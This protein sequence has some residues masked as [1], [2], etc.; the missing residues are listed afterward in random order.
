MLRAGALP[1]TTV[2]WFMDK[3]TATS[4]YALYDPSTVGPRYD[5][6]MDKSLCLNIG[7]GAANFAIKEMIAWKG[8]GKK[9]AQ[10]V[11][12]NIG[13]AGTI[14]DINKGSILLAVYTDVGAN[15]PAYVFDFAVKFKDA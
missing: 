3:N 10:K 7:G 13:N 2:E 11:T 4:W 15:G 9:I 12:Y 14:A 1:A 5:I 6:L 8:W